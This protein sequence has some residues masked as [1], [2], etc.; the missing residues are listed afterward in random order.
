MKKILLFIG[1]CFFLSG[2]GDGVW[3]GRELGSALSGAASS[4]SESLNQ[5]PKVLYTPNGPVYYYPPANGQPG[6]IVPAPSSVPAYQ[7]DHLV[8]DGSGGFYVR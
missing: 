3:S 4:Y 1:L 5:Q 6:Q 8:P 2:C 7:P